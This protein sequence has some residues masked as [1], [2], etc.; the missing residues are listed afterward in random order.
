MNNEDVAKVLKIGIRT[1]DRVKKKFVENGFEGAFEN[2]PTTRVFKRV[3]DGEVEAHLVALSCSK[4]LKVFQNGIYDYYA[5]IKSLKLYP[6][7][8]V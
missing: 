8:Q 2:S 4:A 5:R 6:L 7:I 1:I 3:S